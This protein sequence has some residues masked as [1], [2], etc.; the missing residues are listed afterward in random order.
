MFL[1]IAIGDAY[2]AGFEFSLRQKIIKYNSGTHYAPTH[3]GVPKGHYTDDTQMSIA[4]AEML[5]ADIEF[6]PSHCAHAFVHT[7]KRDPRKGYARQFH[8]LL[9]ACQNGTDLLQKIRPNSIRNG[10]AMRSV[11]LGFIADK[12]T[13]LTAAETQ[14]KITHNTKEGILSSQI[15]ALAAHDL[16]YEKIAIH[17]L[18][19]R[20]H[21][22]LNF[23]FN[24]AWNTKV[25]CDA[26]E[27]IHA[28][29]TALLR[30]H[31]LQ[32][33]LLDCVNFGG[34]VDSVAAI[35]LGLASLS[36]SYHANLNPSLI[37]GLENN[38]YGLDF[39]VDL[40]KKLKQKFINFR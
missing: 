11:P 1:E 19:A 7:F 24:L 10:A 9:Q 18:P 6:N 33:L 5:L 14:A 36:D 16:I 12:N 17:D 25:A 39:L 37:A 27:T 23:S 38:A 40:D 15:I 13:V 4:I 20:I 29:F 21:Q 30:Q 3:F 22:V 35:A 31:N 28:V 8:G 32:D 26:I 2:G 34:D